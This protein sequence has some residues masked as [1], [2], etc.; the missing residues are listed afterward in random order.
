MYQKNFFLRKCAD[1]IKPGPISSMRGEK[2]SSYPYHGKLENS[3]VKHITHLDELAGH[4]DQL[5]L[6]EAKFVK[7]FDLDNK[8]T[9]HMELIGY[10]L[11]FTKI[12]QFQEGGGDNLDIPEIGRSSFR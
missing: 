2:I 3:L 11:Y 7:G 8:F 1:S 4:F 12:E 10:S 6:K 5:G 9:A